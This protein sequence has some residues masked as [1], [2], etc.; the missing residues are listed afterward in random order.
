MNRKMTDE[1]MEAW[2]DTPVDLHPCPKCGKAC[3]C[4]A[5]AGP[6]N[7]HWIRCQEHGV[8]RWEQ[9]ELDRGGLTKCI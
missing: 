8:Q 3:I 6:G 9:E 4:D 5:I 7:K 1:A 2:K